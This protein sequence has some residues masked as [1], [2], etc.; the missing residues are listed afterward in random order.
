MVQEDTPPLY[1]SFAQAGKKIMNKYFS[2]LSEFLRSIIT[3]FNPPVCE[4]IIVWDIEGFFSNCSNF[5]DGAG[6]KPLKVKIQ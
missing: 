5:G 3:F 6:R 2:K 4:E 1:A